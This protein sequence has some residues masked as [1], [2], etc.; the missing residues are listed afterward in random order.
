MLIGQGNDLRPGAMSLEL[1]SM[2]ADLAT[3]TAPTESTTADAYSNVSL[4]EVNASR[5]WTEDVD[6][7]RSPEGRQGKPLS[8]RL[9]PPSLRVLSGTLPT[10]AR[11][12]R[13]WELST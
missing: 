3:T 5:L 9:T 2:A 8:R 6:D 4:G 10:T 13:Y 1:E 11:L 12:G 7:T